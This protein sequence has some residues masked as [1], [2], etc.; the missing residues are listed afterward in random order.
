MRERRALVIASQCDALPTLPMLEAAAAEL[1]GVLTDSALGECVPAL[2]GGVGLLVNRTAAKTKEAIFE[3]YGRAAE[4]GATLILA[5]IGHGEAR[6]DDRFVFLPVDALGESI[7]RRVEAAIDPVQAI[8]DA[9]RESPGGIDGLVLLLDACH[10]GT[11]VSGAANRWVRALGRRL[12]YDLLTATGDL[13]AYHCCFSRTLAA[14]LRE[15][16]RGAGERLRAADVHHALRAECGDQAPENTSLIPG[17]APDP[18]LYLA[19]NVAYDPLGGAALAAIDA[20]IAGH[21][22]AFVPTPVLEDA[23]RESDTRRCVAVVGEAGLGKSTVAA[24]LARPARSG[25]AVPAGFCQAVAFVNENTTPTTLAQALEAQ[26]RTGVTGFAEAARRVE[27]ETPAEEWRHL[28]AL[29]RAVVGPLRLLTGRGAPL[30][31]PGAL[32]AASTAAPVR[33]VVDALDQLPE[34]AQRS[35]HAALGALAA[36]GASLAAAGR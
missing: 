1:Y 34:G 17:Y 12:R 15:G 36:A 11:A 25:G 35:V 22:A 6:G 8:E 21:T 9:Q 14:V 32:A 5:F 31:A 19:R 18:G 27:R 29:Q 33:I 20:Q 4:D 24:A 26:L 10:A 23:V 3:A 28:D 30:T 16:V 2:A 7:A 13:S